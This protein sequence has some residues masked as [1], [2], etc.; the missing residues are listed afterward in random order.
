MLDE[1]S[2]ITD[3]MPSDVAESID[4]ERQTLVMRA[5][6]NNMEP[7]ELEAL[8]LQSHDSLPY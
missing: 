1:V 7:V 6:W 3:D 8:W 5:G 2:P 4:I